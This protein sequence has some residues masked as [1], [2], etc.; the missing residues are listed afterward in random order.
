MICRFKEAFKQFSARCVS[1]NMVDPC[2]QLYNVHINI[3]EVNINIFLLEL[4]KEAAVK[5]YPPC[6]G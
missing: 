4:H 5:Q 6:Q 1:S 3:G 2:V